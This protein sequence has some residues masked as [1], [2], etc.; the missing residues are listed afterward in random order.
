[1]CNIR[2]KPNSGKALD[3]YYF[4]NRIGSFEMLGCL[5]S[6]P[7]LLE[8]L[9][10]WGSNSHPPPP[11]PSSPRIR[12]LQ[13][14]DPRNLNALVRDDDDE[15]DNWHIY[16]AKKWLTE[17]DS[18]SEGVVRLLKACKSKP[19]LRNFK[20]PCR[21]DTTTTEEWHI[22]IYVCQNVYFFQ[23]STADHQ[24]RSRH[25]KDSTSSPTLRVS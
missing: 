15:A 21:D 17:A 25:S 20:W 6:W 7:A 8:W 9:W 22:E 18:W 1:M 13:P 14:L 3:V 11:P 16:A 12:M 23:L 4:N 24:N 2:L 5:T 10:E 19:K